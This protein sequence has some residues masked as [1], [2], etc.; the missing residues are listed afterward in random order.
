M[1]VVAVVLSLVVVI[2]V[3]PCK[4]YLFGQ[5]ITPL[6]ISWK[7]WTNT[8]GNYWVTPFWEPICTKHV[9]PLNTHS[10]CPGSFIL[11]R[12]TVPKILLIRPFNNLY[13]YNI[14]WITSIFSSTFP[15]ILISLSSA[16]VVPATETVVL[17]V[18]AVVEVILAVVVATVV[19]VVLAAVVVVESQYYLFGWFIISLT[20]S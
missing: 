9:G 13:A 19:M 4:Y 2:V 12:S 7:L 8:L 10:W 16:L 5:L 20:I 14:F 17:E 18:V 11:I 15:H 6:I 1:V 3:V